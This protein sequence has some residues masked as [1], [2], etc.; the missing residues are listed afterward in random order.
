MACCTSSTESCC[1][2]TCYTGSLTLPLSCGY[3]LGTGL[4]AYRAGC[5]GPQML[6]P[7]LTSRL[8]GAFPQRNV[9]AAAESFGYKIF[10]GL[11]KVLLPWV[12]L[13]V[14]AFV[15]VCVCVCVCVCVTNV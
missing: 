6:P 7:C 11:V 3:D 13:S 1:R 8:T 5:W 10:S 2:Q 12:G 15:P 9:T 4:G 14:C